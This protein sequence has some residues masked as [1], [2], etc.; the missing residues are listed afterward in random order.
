LDKSFCQVH[1]L[2]LQNVSGGKVQLSQV[3]MAEMAKPVKYPIILSLLGLVLWNILSACGNI[4]A[5]VSIKTAEIDPTKVLTTAVVRPSAVRLTPTKTLVSEDALTA[6][7][8]NC[9]RIAFSLTHQTTNENPAIYTICPDGS[10]LAQLTHF[11][12]PAFSPS[13]SQ[14]GKEIA[15]V[16]SGQI[17]RMNADGS[18]PIAI[19]FEN[20][21]SFPE[22]LPDGKR[23]TFK[24]TDGKGLWWWQIAASDGKNI[25]PVT[26]PSFDFFYQTLARSP[27]GT[28]IAYMSLKEQAERND[29]SSQIHI[30]NADGSK[31]QA[32]THDT[33]ANINPRWSPDGKFISFLS[34]RDGNYGVFAVYLMK[35]DGTTLRR[36]SEPLYSE[37]ATISWAP[38]GLK[39]ALGDDEKGQ[40]ILID[41]VSGQGQPL[42]GLD[43]TTVARSPSWQP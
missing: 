5:P 17:Y 13:W 12:S 11:Q 26:Q 32:L 22:W 21:N 28:K 39:I 18:N 1:G 30:M 31:D 10:G 41:L 43:Q 19:T 7:V 9:H 33:W 29:G 35:A 37:T 23:I 42:L 16:S 25:T 27:D 15:F 6:P 14:D 24:T 8:P 36:L 40:I 2:W 20:A 34:E 4:S 3:I 38:D